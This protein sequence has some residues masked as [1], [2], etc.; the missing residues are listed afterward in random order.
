VYSAAN[1]AA[2]QLTSISPPDPATPLVGSGALAVI[3]RTFAPA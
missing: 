3:A 1:T 2:P